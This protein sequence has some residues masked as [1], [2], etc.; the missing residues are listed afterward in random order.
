MRVFMQ[1][2]DYKAMSR[3][4]ANIISA[5]VIYKPD[6]VLGL[7][8]GGPPWASTSSWWSGTRRATCP[9]PRPAPSTWTSIWACPPPRAELPLLHAAQPV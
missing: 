7:A 9:S 1:C 3:R 2:G 4:A 8:T 5:Q 6:C